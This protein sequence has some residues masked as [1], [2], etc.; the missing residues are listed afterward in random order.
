MLSHPAQSTARTP[1]DITEA[2]WRGETTVQKRQVAPG[3]AVLFADRISPR[4]R[5]TVA[6]ALFGA[7]ALSGGGAVAQ[8]AQPSAPGWQFTVAP[9]LWAPSL[10]GTLRYQLPPGSGNTRRA[11]VRVD[12][13]NLIEALNFAGMIAAE[14]RNGRFTILTDFIHLDLGNAESRVESVD[15]I[16]GGRNRVSGTLDAGT[17]TTLRGTLWTLAGGYTLVDG[18]WGNIDAIAGFRLFSLSARTDVRLSATFNG[19]GPGQS[20]ARTGRISRDTDLF[21]GIIG[22]R[23]GFLLGSGFH[24]PYS[25]DIG[26]GSSRLTWQAAAAIAYQTGWAGVTLGYRHLAY[27]QGGDKLVQDLSFSGPFLAVNFS[28]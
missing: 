20:F 19:P 6:A 9:Y 8:P 2:S 3:E 5:D 16:Q 13:V 1:Q 18:A 15:F 10:D 25:F 24:I 21:D 14:A 12:S 7:V 26:G 11:D 4:I 28:F 23:G 22:V 17:E 27:D